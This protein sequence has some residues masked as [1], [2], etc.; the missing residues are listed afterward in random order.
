VVNLMGEPIAQR[1]TDQAKLRIR[2][3]RVSGT[4][5]LVE[6]IDALPE[7]RRPQVLI[8]QS[9]SG[10]YGA[11]GD[12]QLDEEAAAGSDFLAEVVVAWEQ[13]ALTAQGPRVVLTRTGVVISSSGGALDRMLPFFRLGIGGPVAGGHQY[14]PWVH[15][16]DVVGAIL[17]CVGEPALAGA[18]NVTAP[19]PVTNAELTR[20]LGHVLRRPAVLPVP[21]LALRVLYGEMAQVVSTGQRVVP[22]RLERS[23]YTF[24]YTDVEAALQDALRRG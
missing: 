4:Q 20:A 3:S 8:S 21:E 19:Q 1:W 9:A 14:V 24:R 17:H 16:D 18:V 12:E 7:D 10:Y 2:A 23:G 11:R 6:A 13:A 5:R 15:L 22:A